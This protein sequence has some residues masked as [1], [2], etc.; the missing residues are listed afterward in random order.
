MQQVQQVGIYSLS[1]M[2]LRVVQL[3]KGANNVWLDD[4]SIIK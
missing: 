3:Q 1:G 4:I 2:L